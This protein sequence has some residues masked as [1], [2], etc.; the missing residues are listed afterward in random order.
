[1]YIQRMFAR[2]S[3]NATRTWLMAQRYA[4]HIAARIKYL[5]L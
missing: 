3:G 5:I 4:V 2:T 1:M